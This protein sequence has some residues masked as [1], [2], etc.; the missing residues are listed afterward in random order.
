MAEKKKD[1]ARVQLKDVRLS[2]AHLF[3]P[4]VYGDGDGEPKHNCNLLIDDSTRVGKANIDAM[5]DAIEFVK[6]EKWPKGAPKLGSQ[7]I[8]LRDGNDTEYDGYE[9]VFYVSASNSRKPLTLDRDK[10]EVV[11]ADGVLYSG[12]Y[13]DAIVRVWAQDN[14]YGKRI[15]ASIEAVRFRRD[16]EAFG[17]APPDADEFDDL[18]DEDDG[19]DR[20]S[21]R[22]S[23]KSRDDDGDDRSSRRSR[24]SRDEESDDD[25]DRPSRRSSRR[26]R[27]E[28]GDDDD[29][30]PSRRSSR[31]SRDEEEDDRSSRRSS[32]RS[33][34]EE[35]DDDTDRPSR[36][37]RS[38]RRRDEDDVV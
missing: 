35:G 3:K 12:C 11:E 38:R 14:K 23:R 5:E 20:S 36:N 26:S 7:K 21:R 17:A 22:S 25:D 28:E 34:D 16:G 1:P 19:D 8:C 18:D 32:R 6:K 33:R 24:R 30:R 13:V 29:D 2:F 9:D 31:R 10:T 15:N 27:D 37:S 4:Q